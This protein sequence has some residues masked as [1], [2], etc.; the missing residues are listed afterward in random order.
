MR[1]ECSRLGQGIQQM[2]VHFRKS[3]DVNGKNKNKNKK[4]EGEAEI[5]CSGDFLPLS[6]PPKAHWTAFGKA[7]LVATGQWYLFFR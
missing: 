5:R 1:S 3:L 2:M 6:Q 4:T 7:S